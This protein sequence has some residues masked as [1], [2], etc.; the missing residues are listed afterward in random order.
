[1]ANASTLES[2]GLSLNVFKL[3]LC[4]LDSQLVNAL[5]GLLRH[6][7]AELKAVPGALKQSRCGFPVLK[8][9]KQNSRGHGN[10]REEQPG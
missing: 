6:A 1:M 9:D 7:A 10:A 2:L 3:K 5:L 8:I 4:L